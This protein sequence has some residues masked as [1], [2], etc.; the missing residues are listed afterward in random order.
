MADQEEVK[1]TDEK[2]PEKPEQQEAPAEESEVAAKNSEQPPKE[3]RAVVPTGIVGPQ[4]VKVLQKTKPTVGKGE[5]LI[6]VKVS[7]WVKI[8]KI[9]AKECECQSSGFLQ[10]VSTEQL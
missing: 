8:A 6:R 4:Y 3:M 5:G 9:N 10:C 2:A 1:A 7:P